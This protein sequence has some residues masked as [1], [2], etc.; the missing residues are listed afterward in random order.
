M[1]TRM[2]KK[3]FVCFTW[4]QTGDGANV[5]IVRI[6]DGFDQTNTNPRPGV[7]FMQTLGNPLLTTIS[8][9]EWLQVKEAY[10][11]LRI[12]LCD[13]EGGMPDTLQEARD[14]AAQAVRRTPPTI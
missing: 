2:Q 10:Q 6:A 14:I 3:N 8:L 7:N 1:W 12:A 11:T 9:A 4:R 5:C 13:I